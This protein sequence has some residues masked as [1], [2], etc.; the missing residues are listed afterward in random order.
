MGIKIKK[1]HN[2]IVGIQQQQQ[3]KETGK[4]AH[5]KKTPTRFRSNRIS[6]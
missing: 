3:Q 4:K 5:N 6:M 2:N 1:I